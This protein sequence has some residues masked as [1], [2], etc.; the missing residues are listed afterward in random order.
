MGDRLRG[1]KAELVQRKEAE[2]E[3]EE[4]VEGDNMAGA[5]AVAVAVTA[6]RECRGAVCSVQRLRNYGEVQSVTH[7]S[8]RVNLPRARHR[9]RPRCSAVHNAP[10]RCQ[11]WTDLH[12]AATWES[13]ST[14]TTNK[15]N[16]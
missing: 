14:Q 8:A 5:V 4:L 9:A 10:V 7:C 15:V 1:G 13:L 11:S 6:L 2:M 12:Q 3:I 16:Y